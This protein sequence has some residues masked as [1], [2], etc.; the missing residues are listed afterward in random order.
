MQTTIKLTTHALR[1]L[2]GEAF[3][4]EQYERGRKDAYKY[5]QEH[6]TEELREKHAEAVK[7]LQN[8]HSLTRSRIA[9]PSYWIGCV[10]VI[11]WKI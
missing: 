4:F 2:M 6:S 3:D 8:P 9:G 7:K 10:D 11:E 5:I 1:E